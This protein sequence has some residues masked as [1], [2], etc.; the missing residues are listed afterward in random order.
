MTKA[1]IVQ[2]RSYEYDDNTYTASEG[3][4]AVRAYTSLAAATQAAVD[5]TVEGF[6][7][8]DF[9]YLAE[10]AAFKADSEAFEV[11]ESHGFE[12]IDGYIRWGEAR[13]ISEAAQSGAF[14]DEDLRKI[15]RSLNSYYAIYFVQEVEVD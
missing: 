14:T 10:V 15:A 2:R 6:K 4:N 11:I 9:D 8:G 7:E 12:L 1:Y 3:G 5:M 13:E